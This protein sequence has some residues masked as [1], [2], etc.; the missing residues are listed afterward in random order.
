MVEPGHEYGRV[1]EGTTEVG[2]PSP[3]QFQV[4]DSSKR[5]E[6]VRSG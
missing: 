5:G 2:F 3:S 1:L 6:V 4:E